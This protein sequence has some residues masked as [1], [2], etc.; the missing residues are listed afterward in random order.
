LIT[1]AKKT[2]K[3]MIFQRITF[4]SIAVIL[5]FSSCSRV[6]NSEVFIAYIKHHNAHEVDE[7]MKLF[8][9]DAKLYLPGQPPIS[10]IRKVEAWDAAI[11]GQSDYGSW[12]V[13]G[14]TIKVG[15]I[16]ERNRWFKRANIDKVE[17]RPGSRFIFQD[18]KIIEIRLTEMT[19]E[20][21][22][23]VANMFQ[24]FI[25]WA[26]QERPSMVRQLMPNGK[27]DLSEEK[28]KDWFLLMD[29]WQQS[30]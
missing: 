21:Q 10:D 1:F 17:Y 23:E 24:E 19:I 12:Q 4:I 5:I 11:G 15:T 27:F 20:S 13:S 6:D 2:N 18:G 30:K 22:A 28:A 9:E 25:T 26:Q 3:D 16:I 29:Q 14:D 7:T 8:H